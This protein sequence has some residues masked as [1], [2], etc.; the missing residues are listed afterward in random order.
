VRRHRQQDVRGHADGEAAVGVVDAQA[1][2]E[3]LDVALRQFVL[4]LCRE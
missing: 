4:A 1:D 3:R 2:L